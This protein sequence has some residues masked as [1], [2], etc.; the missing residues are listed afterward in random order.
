MSSPHRLATPDAVHLLLLSGRGP[1]LQ[2][3]FRPARGDFAQGHYLSCLVVLAH[4]PSYSIKLVIRTY[5]K[6]YRACAASWLSPAR[7]SRCLQ[8]GTRPSLPTKH[9]MQTICFATR[10]IYTPSHRNSF[11]TRRVDYDYIE[12][13]IGEQ[14]GV[15]GSK[16]SSLICNT[17][18][19][20]VVLHC[21]LCRPN[22]A[23]IQH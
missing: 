16:S 4:K 13:D 20:F 22:T 21:F 11:L 14:S 7:G 5:A 9:P 19:M 3:F 6:L 10:P 17:I 15:G 2:V 1:F 8:L 12:V 23:S 18:R